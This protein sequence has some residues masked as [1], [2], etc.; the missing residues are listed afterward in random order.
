LE[1]PAEYEY[2]HRIGADVVGM[3]TVPEVLAAKHMGMRIFVVSVV[4][5]KSYPLSAIQPTTVESVIA[6][7][8]RVSPKVQ[9]VVKELVRYIQ[10]VSNGGT[11]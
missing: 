6:T 9:E 2:L 11:Q 1:T 10:A 5:N 8:N 3:S 7:V 4:S